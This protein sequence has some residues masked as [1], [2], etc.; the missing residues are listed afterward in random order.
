MSTC[1]NCNNN[2]F[3]I[4]DTNFIQFLMDYIYFKNNRTNQNFLTQFGQFLS[5]ICECS[6]N[7]KINVSEGLFDRYLEKHPI[8]PN[9]LNSVITIVLRE[10]PNN[11]PSPEDISLLP[12]GLRNSDRTNI[13]I[14]ISEDMTLLSL[15]KDHIIVNQDFEISQN[16]FVFTRNLIPKGFISFLSPIYRDCKFSK[17]HDIISFYDEYFDAFLERIQR[18]YILRGRIRISNSYASDI[19][20]HIFL[21]H[22]KKGWKLSV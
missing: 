9:D 3:I 20:E 2:G 15:L 8:S 11:P 21:K 14:L 1:N 22:I 19:V 5:W 7:N 12:L 13:S 18:P 4:C 6:T 10:Y 16:D 17:L